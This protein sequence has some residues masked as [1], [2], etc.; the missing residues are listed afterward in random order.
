MFLVVCVLTLGVALALSVAGFNHFLLDWTTQMTFMAV[1][2]LTFLID[3]WLEHEVNLW[4]ETSATFS[5]VH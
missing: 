3:R 5:D 2:I 1:L 4:Y